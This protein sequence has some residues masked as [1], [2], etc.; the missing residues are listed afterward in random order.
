ME[1]A[2]APQWE[3]QRVVGGG[4][5]GWVRGMLVGSSVSSWGGHRG[6]GRGQ[7]ELEDPKQG[8]GCELSPPLCCLPSLLL[9]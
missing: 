9:V 3:Q 7:R 4:G 8:S 6:G 5:A 2:V 1:K